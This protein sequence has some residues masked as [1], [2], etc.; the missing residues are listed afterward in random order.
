MVSLFTGYGAIVTPLN[1]RGEL[2]TK[3]IAF[4][5]TPKLLGRARK[6]L[7]LRPASFKWIKGQGIYCSICD[8]LGAYLTISSPFV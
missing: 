8:T 5:C 6:D 4:K 3:P 2:R 1:V 7:D